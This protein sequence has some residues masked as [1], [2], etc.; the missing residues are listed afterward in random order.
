MTVFGVVL[1]KFLANY[2]L[3][4]VTVATMLHHR[5]GTRTYAQKVFLAALVQLWS[6]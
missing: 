4:M 3:L 2:G 5:A 1:Q 6:T